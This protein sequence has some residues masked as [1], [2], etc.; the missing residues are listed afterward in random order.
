MQPSPVTAPDA[1]SILFDLKA[2]V[3]GIDWEITEIELERLRDEVHRLENIFAGSRPKQIFLQGLGTLAAYIRFKKSDAHADAFKLLH[4]FVAGLEKIVTVPM[5]L[6]EE[7]RILLPEV[8]KFNEFK[9]IVGAK[10]KPSKVEEEEFSEDEEEGA[11]LHPL[12]RLRKGGERVSGRRRGRCPG[13]LFHFDGRGAGR[14]VFTDSDE[15]QFE[16]KADQFEVQ[17]G[18]DVPDEGGEVVE[19]RLDAMFQADGT[20]AGPG[21]G[22]GRVH[23]GGGRRVGCG[24]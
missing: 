9:A 11:Q 8:E 12:V 1:G 17:A 18:R 14:Q 19:S 24:M 10:I 20:P 23:A 5:S 13:P 7:K 6:E 2:L 4:S 22:P 16:E 21:L 15:P 3:L